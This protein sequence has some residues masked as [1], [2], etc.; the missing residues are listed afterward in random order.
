[1]S[2]R[3]TIDTFIRGLAAT[4]ITLALIT[5]VVLLVNGGG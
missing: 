5:L 3:T 1:M 2:D 4:A